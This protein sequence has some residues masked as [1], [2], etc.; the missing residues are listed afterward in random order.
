MSGDK[1]LTQW[2]QQAQNGDEASMAHLADLARR[3]VYAYVYRILLNEDLVQDVVQEVMLNMVKSLR[4]LKNPE[5]FWPWLYRMS[6]SKVQQLFRRRQHD[7]STLERA[8]ALQAL[9]GNEVSAAG[10]GLNKLL[11][12]ELGDKVFSAMEHLKLRHRCV[13][14]LRC[15]DQMPYTEIARVMDCSETNVR[16]ML[17]RAKLSLKRQ[18]AKRGIKGGL[19]LAALTVFGQMTAPAEV[20][21]ETITIPAGTMQSGLAATILAALLTKTGMITTGLIFMTALTVGTLQFTGPG[22][23]SEGMISQWRFGEKEGDTV[24]DAIGNRSGTIHGATWTPQGVAG[25]L[26]FNGSGDYVR[27]P[28]IILRDFTVC[29]WMQTTQQAPQAEHWFDGNGLVDADSPGFYDWGTA[30]IDGGKVAFGLRE[31]MPITTTIKSSVTVNDGNWHFVVA[32]R[33]TVSRR[34][35]LYIDG[36][37]QATAKGEAAKLDAVVFIGVGNNYLDILENDEWFS[38]II[39]EVTIYEIA[40]TEQ[41]ITQLYTQ[42]AKQL[43]PD[44]LSAEKNR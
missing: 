38:G 8:V 13:L 4:E 5:R 21:A 11:R 20:T 34:M 24:N 32:T 17:F 27:L 26:S 14:T 1:S 31:S 43:K 29:F 9:R 3:R 12:Q 28:R 35:Q 7:H 33:D 44:A 40:L 19:L 16:V 6:W 36:Q 10:E 23:L 42:T 41:Q 15:F 30:L 22:D 39:D 18:L 25:A 37:L 2:V